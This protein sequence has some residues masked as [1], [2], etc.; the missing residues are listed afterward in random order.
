VQVTG[1][2]LHRVGVLSDLSNSDSVGSSTEGATLELLDGSWKGQCSMRL[3]QRFWHLL[4]G[5]RS[6]LSGEAQSA[7]S[8]S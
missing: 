3:H 4:R 7:K 5:K 1:V 8:L 6:H 2:R